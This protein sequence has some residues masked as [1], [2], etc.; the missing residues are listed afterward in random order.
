SAAFISLIAL[1]ASGAVPH[2]VYLDQEPLRYADPRFVATTVIA[3]S[4][5]FFS[6][7]LWVNWV[8]YQL[9]RERDTAV[10]AQDDLLKA[11]GQLQLANEGLELRIQLRPAELETA[12]VALRE[13]AQRLRTVVANAPVVLFALDTEGVFTLAEGK[14]LDDIGTSAEWLIGRSVY[15]IYSESP[16]VLEAVRRALAGEQAAVVAESGEVALEAHMGPVLG[17]GGEVLGVIGVSTNITERRRSERKLEESDEHLRT[18][19]ENVDAIVW[20]ADATTWRFTFASRQ[21]EKILGYPVYQWTEPDFWANH[22]HP[23]DREYAVAFCAKATAEGK[24]HAFDYRMVA[25]DGR[26]V[27]LHDVVRVITDGQGKPRQLRGIMIDITQRKRAEEALWESEEKYRRFFENVQDIF[28]RT[29]LD[30]AILE[31]SPS[32]E[33][34]GYTREELIGTSVLDV[35]YDADERAAF[36]KTILE[37]GEVSDYEIRLKTGDGAVVETSITAH[38]FRGP[39][40]AP[41]GFEGVIRDIRERKRAEEALREQARRD[42]LTGLLNHA[43]IVEELRSVI[44]TGGARLSHAVAMVDVDGLKAVNDTY[45]HQAGDAVLLAVAQALARDGALVGRYGGDEF[46]AVL[47]DSDRTAAERY[48]A[49]VLDTLAGAGITDAE[50]GTNVPVVASIGLAIYPEE[51]ETIED[52]IRLSDSAMYAWRRQRPVIPGEL[53][54]AGRLSSDRAAKMIGELV[55]LLT[56]PSQLSDKLRLVAQQLSVGAGYDGVNFSLFSDETGAPL[57]GSTFARVPEELVE[58]WRDDQSPG[59]HERH[60]IRVLFERVPRPVIMDDPWNDERLYPSQRELLRAAGLRSVLV[61]P[62]IWQDRAVGS[63][64][65]ASKQEAAFT[66][67]DAQFLAAVATQVTAIVQMSAL[68]EKL[69]ASASRLEQ[70]QD[71]TILLLAAAAEAHDQA[72]G[73]HL[74]GVRA[75]TEA[76]AGEL[77]HSAEE[78]RE[79]GLAAVLHDIGKIRIPEAVLAHTGQLAEEEWELVK[80]HATWGA[81][82]LAGRPG[83]ELA[84]TIAGSHHERWDGSGY[85][86][87]LAGD[88]IPQASAIVAVADS[89]DAMIGDR[90]YRKGQSVA[91]AVREIASCSGKQFSPTVVEALLR[92]HRSKR[93]PA[94]ARPSSRRAA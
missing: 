38:V 43:V 53:R 21:A 93:L 37:Q 61:V 35:Y 77:G 88:A 10:R 66:P 24:D 46:V 25:R 1:E 92:L 45:G 51:A 6:I 63:L 31:L 58:S 5:V 86:H 42:P 56:S 14:A 89:F 67:L 65:V 81:Q 60:P 17:P 79:L 23:E 28:Y 8:G 4:G 11:R 22:L 54:P 29:A 71:E 36:V 72:T 34:Y 85:P 82:L 18:L 33:R 73:R 83:F 26:L 30:S 3:S 7:F 62:M 50:T 87:G 40:G 47:R 41:A 64:G 49:V 78:A 13:S 27:W 90:P 69:H 9:R 57:A 75:L 44:A 70:T 91:Q 74:Q 94:A 55:P 20:E 39:D 84:A 59:R 15:E 48:R 16:E 19:I 52:L 32:V 76:L 80:L 2:Y 12:N 68:V